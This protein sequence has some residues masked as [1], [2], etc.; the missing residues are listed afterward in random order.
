MAI[1]PLLLENNEASCVARGTRDF[2]Y[3]PAF[4]DVISRVPIEQPYKGC[5][6]MLQSFEQIHIRCA[7]NPS[8]PCEGCVHFETEVTPEFLKW[9]LN[10]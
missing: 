3:D 9:W 10:N 6:P 8:G 1:I 5:L 2:E 7:I 4:V